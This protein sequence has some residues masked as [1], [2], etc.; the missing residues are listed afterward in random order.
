MAMRRLLAVLGLTAMAQELAC[1]QPLGATFRTQAST[2]SRGGLV[3]ARGTL[4]ARFDLDDCVGWGRTTSTPNRRV[5]RGATVQ[6]EDKNG[7]TP[8]TWTLVVYGEDPATPGFPAVAAPL[9]VAG[10]FSTGQ[11][12][13]GLAQWAETV[14]FAAPLEVPADRDL[15]VGVL[16]ASA[17]AWPADGL[18]VQCVLGA[19]SQWP[20]YDQP[21]TA[22]IQ[23]G[24][25]GLAVDAAGLRFYNSTRQLLIDLLTDAPGGSCTALGNQ[26]SYPIGSASPGSGG[27]LSAAHPD[28][29]APA[30][31]AGRA[32][33]PGFALLDS[34]LPNGSPVFFLLDIGAF[35]AEQPFAAFVP[36]S[37]GV[38]CLKPPSMLVATIG[39]AFG[40]TASFQVPLS[41]GQR[42]W[43][44]GLPLLYQGVAMAPSLTL[45]ATPCLRQ[46]L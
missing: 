25:Y 2:A 41:S 18:A 5:V 40:G 46:V 1:Q 22:P 6:L 32:D 19:P 26:S 23:H 38:S 10:P 13:A 39:L 37:V 14:V 34:A 27:Y 28:A 35:A 31:Q 12:P 15:F 7:A 24:S 29:S 9:R 43:L 20:V 21:G 45:R 33:V 30:R 3:T 11:R 8:E 16:V 17:P 36:G 44:R 4:V 42:T